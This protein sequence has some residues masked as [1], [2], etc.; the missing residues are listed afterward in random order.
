MGSCAH[1]CDQSRHP[2]RSISRSLSDSQLCL[3]CRHH[4]P[5]LGVAAWMF[6]APQQHRLLAMVPESA[7]VILSLNASAIYF[8]IGSGAAAGGFVLHAASLSTLGWVGGWCEVLALGLLFLSTHL[9]SKRTAESQPNF[10][11]F[12]KEGVMPYR[13]CKTSQRGEEGLQGPSVAQKWP[14]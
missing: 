12:S 8:G 3:R 11:H 2:G 13:R 4:A 9:P 1:H 7:S 10:V 6:I 14:C 5:G